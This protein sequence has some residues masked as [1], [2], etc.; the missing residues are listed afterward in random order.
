MRKL[1]MGVAALVVLGA[2]PAA[3]QVGWESPLLTPPRNDLGVGVYLMETYAG[4]VGVMAHWRGAPAPAG[5]GIRG[6]IAEG[7]RDDGIA[8]FGGLDLAGTLTRGEAADFPLAVD[9]VL[10]IGASV[11]DDLVIS[12]PAGITVGHSFRAENATFAPF[13]TPRVV[14]DAA[15]GSEDELD[16][17]FAADLG[18]DLQ[19][20]PTWLIRFGASLGRDALA[21]GVVF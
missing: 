3:A 18:L 21:V 17:D 4:G 8:V 13:L 20:A 10:G 5:F 19:F 1:A 11:G 2:A 14:L 7:R 15:F 12:V 6:G 16:L 9:W